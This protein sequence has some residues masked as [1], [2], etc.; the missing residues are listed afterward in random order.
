MAPAIRLLDSAVGLRPA[1]HAFRGATLTSDVAVRC[2]PIYL[3]RR[4]EYERAA[5]AANLSEMD[6]ARIHAPFR[7]DPWY[8]GDVRDVKR[9]TEYLLKATM[10]G[11]RVAKHVLDWLAPRVWTRVDA[12]G[13]KDEYFKAIRDGDRERAVELGRAV[14][15]RPN[16]TGMM[17]LGSA[18]Q[19]AMAA[20]NIGFMVARGEGV[21]KNVMEAVK[22]YEMAIKCGSSAA[23]VNLGLLFY[24]GDEVGR[25][26]VKARLLYETALERGERDYAPRNLGILLFHGGGGVKS[27]VVGAARLLLMGIR[28]GN[29]DAKRKC[30]KSLAIVMRSWRMRLA[31]ASLR[32]ECANALA[33]DEMDVIATR[34]AAIS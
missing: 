3:V 17:R 11:N 19:R 34:G 33:S 29:D 1:V 26:L 30:R 15:Q 25:D 2:L 28:E 6:I 13:G 12:A 27:D 4:V 8:I 10:T 24:N 5:R 22:Y 16:E 31:P 14:G 20:N 32:R 9:G 7:D 18:E 23:C 21:E